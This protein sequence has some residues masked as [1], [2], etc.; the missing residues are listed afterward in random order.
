MVR[1]PVPA[2]LAI[3][4]VGSFVWCLPFVALGAA[5]GENWDVI[6]GP[7]KAAGLGV[8]VVIVGLL[9]VSA[10]RQLRRGDAFD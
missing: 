1:F 9:V 7:A 5:L 2:F 10:A 3:T 4:F 8:L 6:E